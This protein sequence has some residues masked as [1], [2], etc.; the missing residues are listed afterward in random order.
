MER[1]FKLAGVQLTGDATQTFKAQ[2][3]RVSR[4]Q[5]RPN[6]S[7]WEQGPLEAERKEKVTEDPQ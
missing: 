7:T 2:Q 3:P 5:E 4:L 1:V 6:T